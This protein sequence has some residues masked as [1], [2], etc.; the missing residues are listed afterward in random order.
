MLLLLLP[1]IAALVPTPPLRHRLRV[2]IEDTDCYQIV[3]CE[4]TH[5]V[6][7]PFSSDLTI[8]PDWFLRVCTGT[9]GNYLRFFERAAA[10]AIGTPRLGRCLRD[11]GLT[12]GLHYADGLRYSQAA[13]L[14]DEC[15]VISTPL[16]LDEAG[17]LVLSVSLVRVA[18]GRELIAASDLRFGFSSTHTGLSPAWPLEEPKLVVDDDATLLADPYHTADEEPPAADTSPPLPLEAPLR[19]QFDECDAHGGLSLHAVARYFERHRT[20]YLGGPDGL[21]ELQRD[22]GVNVVVARISGFRL[23]PAAFDAEADV[24]V[25]CA[26]DL[27]CR[28]VLAGKRVRFEQWLMHGESAAPLARADVECLCLDSMTGKIVAAPAAVRKRLLAWQL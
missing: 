3:F 23:M 16:G 13:R 10:A 19:L 26:L 6:S 24:R 15:D 20:T 21:E 2:Y 25:G 5:C 7:L 27:R 11:R 18:D 1:V 9:D 17:R 22:S 12:F 8:K 14:G 4:S 28:V